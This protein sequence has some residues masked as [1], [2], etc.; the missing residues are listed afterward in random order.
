MRCGGRA[1]CSPASRGL[2]TFE[3]DAVT[4]ANATTVRTSRE[5]GLL[6]AL[7]AMYRGRRRSS[8]HL[9]EVGDWLKAV[10]LVE[11]LLKQPSERYGTV[12]H[13]ELIDVDGNRLVWWQTRG[14]PLPSGRAIHLRGRVER[15]SYFGRTTITVLARCRALDRRPHA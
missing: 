6:C 12:C 8:R 11:R 2:S 10:V 9:G 1:S 3:R 4:V 13:H 14:T 15:H 7:I 5:R